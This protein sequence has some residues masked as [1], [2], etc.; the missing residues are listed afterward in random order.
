MSLQVECINLPLVLPDEVGML[1]RLVAA[2]DGISVHQFISRAVVDRAEAIGIQ[3]LA[4]QSAIKR[5]GAAVARL[6]HNQEV[7]GSI[8][9]PATT[10]GPHGC[11][12]PD[13]AGDDVRPPVGG[14]DGRFSQ[15]MR[16]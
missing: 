15:E 6:A 4:D 2:H 3:G 10:F 14:A 16:R 11:R 7:D 1:L 8:P 12:P 13:G 5:D 9:S